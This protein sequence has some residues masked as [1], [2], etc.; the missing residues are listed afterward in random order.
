MFSSKKVQ[1]RIIADSQY[2]PEEILIGINRRR[3]D[4]HDVYQLNIRTGKLTLVYENNLF[5]S[6][7]CNEKLKIK[8]AI[9]TTPDGGAVVYSLEKNFSKTKLFTIGAEDILTTSPLSLNKKEDVLYLLDSRDRNTAALASINLKTKETNIIA[10]DQKADIDEVLFHP[11]ELIP[12]G[13]RVT[14]EKQKWFTIDPS[15]QEDLIYLK[16]ISSGAISIVNGSLDN[17]KWIVVYNR[18][19]GAPRYYFY[20]RLV[21]KAYFLFS[22]RSNLDKLPLTPMKTVI[23]SSRDNFPLISYLSLPRGIN[24][25][26]DLDSKVP[27]VLL[28]HGGPNARDYWGY[29]G[30]HQWLANRGYA[31]LSVNYRGSSGFGKTFINAGNGEWG[32]K[33]HDDLVDAVQWAIDKGITAPGKIAIMGGSYGGYA[34]LIGLTKT[35]DLFA[36]GIDIVGPSNLQT[37]MKSIPAYWKPYYASFKKKIG[38]DPDTKEGQAFL[39]ERSPITYVNR[40]KKPLLIGHGANDPRVKLEESEQIVQLMISNNIPVTYILYPD[41]GHGFQRPENRLS[42]Y[43][44]A[45]NFLAKN[46][47]GR[48]EPIK[49]KDFKNSTIQIK[50]GKEYIS[51]LKE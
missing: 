39:K 47:K 6:F 14:Y 11:K 21:K 44:V 1:G 50:A 35:P 45:E 13:Y 27:L 49:K 15:F 17:Q 46:L 32:A 34:T 36:C 20:D 8:L 40:I 19:V 5:S 12:L 23:I 42:F 37:L 29:N 22:G 31:V 51:A 26:K 48:R 33:M 2:F 7:I 38:G 3:A 25:Y 30:I 41:E 10:S 4:F 16:G 43:A 28:V 18:D 9:E 24:K